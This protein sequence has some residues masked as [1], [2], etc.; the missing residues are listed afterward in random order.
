MLLLYRLPCLCLH[1][2]Y[3]G[4][5]SVCVASSIDDS[6]FCYQSACNNQTLYIFITDNWFNC[7]SHDQII[8]VDL[9]TDGGS[10]QELQCPQFNVTCEGRDGES[11]SSQQSLVPTAAENNE[12]TTITP[13][14]TK[15]D[16]I[17]NFTEDTPFPSASP[18]GNMTDDDM[19]NATFPPSSNTTDSQ[20]TP[21]P[22][23]S[24]GNFTSNNAGIVAN[25]NDISEFSDVLDRLGISPGSAKT[26]FAP[27]NDAFEAFSADESNLWNLYQTAAYLLHRE[28][29]MLWHLVTEDVFT[30]DE[31][32]N[33]ERTLMETEKGNITIDQQRQRLDGVPRNAIVDPNVESN[34][35]IV[36]VTSR[37]IVPPY[38]QQS[39]IQQCLED[40]D[41]IL[42][43]STMANLALFVGLDEEIN[44]VYEGGV[45]F[46]VPPNRR[47]IR[48]EIDV[49][50]L[51]TEELADYTRDF[52]LCH[53]IDGNHYEDAVFALHQEQGIDE[54][55]MKTY[56][57]TT[58]WITTTEDKLRFQSRDVILPDQLARNG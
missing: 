53:M 23:E 6:N 15:R 27:N 30:T 50:S 47:F 35:G 16:N 43:F 49:P 38:L 33:G 34:D 5:N 9:G 37:V 8:E 31:I 4:E 11:L 22:T 2:E 44:R 25:R 52:V 42:A 41:A 19:F 57:G 36:H 56:L 12:T 45:T 54:M 10:P 26:V 29:L 32:F 7:E 14:P 13:T 28:E 1:S 39:I 17:F 20:G 51:L 18:T 24:P 55:M 58:I 21:S 46:L 3:F 40:R 48:A